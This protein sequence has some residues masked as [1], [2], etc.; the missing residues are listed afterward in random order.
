MR[1]SSGG[2]LKRVRETVGKKSEGLED[3]YKIKK[4]KKWRERRE[5]EQEEQEEKK[6]RKK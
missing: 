2:K 6:K 5:E 4:R 1:V 3:R